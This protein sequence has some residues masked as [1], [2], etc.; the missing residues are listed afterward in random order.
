MTIANIL[1][2]FS[3]SALAVDGLT[4]PFN[5]PEQKAKEPLCSSGNTFI[6]DSVADYPDTNPGDGYCADDLGRCTL[7]AAIQEANLITGKDTIAFGIPGSGPHTIRP[8]SALPTIADP[9]IIDGYTQ[10]GS[11]PNSAA[12]K[13]GLN[14]LL[15]IELDGSNLEGAA[16]VTR[17]G[18]H[19]TSGN[20]TVRGL[21]IN[22]CCSAIVMNGNGNN[23]VEGNF[24]GTD[25]AGMVAL[26]NFTGVTTYN[27]PDNNVIGGSTAASRNLISGNELGIE[28]NGGSNN[29][30]RGN[31]IG[32]NKQGEGDLGHDR[33]SIRLNGSGYNLIADNV[34][35]NSRTGG[36]ILWEHSPG[37][38]IRD[39]IVKANQEQDG[40]AIIGPD[41]SDNQIISNEVTA[42]D[43]N[44]IL[45]SNIESFTVDNNIITSNGGDGLRLIDT[46]NGHIAG[47]LI[48]TDASGASLGNSGHGVLMIESSQTQVGDSENTIAFNGKSGITLELGTGNTLHRNKLYQNRELGIDLEGDGVTANDLGDVDVGPNQLQNFP[49]LTYATTMNT[50]ITG[51]IQSAAYVTYKLHFFTNRVCDSSRHGEGENYLGQLQVTTGSDGRAD[52]VATFPDTKPTGSIVTSLATDLLNNTSEFSNCIFFDQRD[53][54]LPVILS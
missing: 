46:W 50:T 44:G 1:A 33:Y 4:A 2:G 3:H 40:I 47:N 43:R 16:A 14:T 37:N 19:I 38:V 54:Y 39:N 45:L 49:V 24:L 41:V 51:T 12:A 28:L 20:S 31:L 42:N 10:S 23:I 21:V 53:I 25:V 34:V 32:T 7:R 36:I 13:S 29:V 30:I 52:F 27:Y 5:P 17:S 15:K 48:G 22:R 8:D 35:A 9:V 18:L 11:R 6:V 26:S